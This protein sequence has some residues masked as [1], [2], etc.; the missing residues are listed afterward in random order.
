MDEAVKVIVRCRPINSREE[1]LGCKVVVE[2]DAK[3][4]Q[5][6][7]HKPGA[8]DSKA[9]PKSFTFDGTYYMYDHTKLIYDD[10]CFNLVDNVLKGTQYMYI[11]V[12]VH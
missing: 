12:L 8:E 3:L 4:C 2:M 5:V 10:I 1:K 9:V 11:S 6:R 7:L